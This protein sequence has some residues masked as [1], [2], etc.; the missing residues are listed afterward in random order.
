MYSPSHHNVKTPVINI[1]STLCPTPNLCNNV[2][3]I[4]L[5]GSNSNSNTISMRSDMCVCVCVCVYI[6]IYIYIY[7]HTYPSQYR[8]ADWVKKKNKK[9]GTAVNAACQGNR[10]VCH[11]GHACHRFT[12]PVLGILTLQM[13]YFTSF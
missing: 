11:F 6:Y 3:L 9:I 8:K 5:F 4:G 1:Q 10:S 7:I 13:A 12:S 2:S